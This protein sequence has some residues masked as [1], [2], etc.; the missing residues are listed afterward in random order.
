MID[1][2]SSTRARTPGHTRGKW[3]GIHAGFVAAAGLAG[4]ST[5]KH[6]EQARARAL[7]AEREAEQLY[8]SVVETLREGVMLLSPRGEVRAAN[9]SAARILGTTVDRMIGATRWRATAHRPRGRQ[10]VGARRP[11]GAGHRPHRRGPARAGHGPAPRRRG[12]DLDLALLAPAA[13]RGDGWASVVSLA[14]I[15]ERKRAQSELEHLADHDPLTGL[16]NRRRL[17]GDVAATWPPRALRHRRRGAGPGPGQLQVRER[18]ARPRRGRPA[19]LPRGRG[20]H[21]PPAR[22]RHRGPPGRRR[23]RRGAAPRGRRRRRARGPMLLEGDPRGG[24]G[25]HD[26]RAAPDHGQHRHRADVARP[27]HRGADGPGRHRHVR[28]QGAGQ[29]PRPGVRPGR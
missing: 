25:Q 11:S 7:E 22:E 3:A 17:E 2:T 5:W 8:R 26:G 29:G 1:P 12:A 28:G 10:P 16:L 23:V 21:R 4:V 20:D 14:D 24:G 15:T 27:D 9:A 19:D 6:N 13:P 18:L